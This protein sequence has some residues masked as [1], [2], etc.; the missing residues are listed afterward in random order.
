MEEKNFLVD[1]EDAEKIGV[2]EVL[3]LCVLIMLVAVESGF[4][5]LKAL[6]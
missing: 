6:L 5:K 2:V 1:L 3:N 4:K